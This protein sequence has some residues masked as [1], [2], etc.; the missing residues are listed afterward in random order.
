MQTGILFHAA[1]FLR[2]FSIASRVSIAGGA[3]FAR[4]DADSK[5]ESNYRSC[6][7]C[8][9]RRGR[10]T[11]WRMFVAAGGFR[12]FVAARRD[13][14]A[15]T[16]CRS[17]DGRAFAVVARDRAM[18]IRPERRRFAAARNACPVRV[19]ATRTPTPLA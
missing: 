19:P 9:P 8:H 7:N 5:P 6:D 13:R 1:P 4:F 17:G 3:A 15:A 12:C 11:V 16:P 14:R 2:H 18:S 10:E